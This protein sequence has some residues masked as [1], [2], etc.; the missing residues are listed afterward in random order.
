MFLITGESEKP[1]KGKS[2]E[3]PEEE[4]PNFIHRTIWLV[5]I[6]LAVSISSMT[7]QALLDKSMDPPG[8][9]MMNN[10][11]VR[12]AGRTVYIIIIMCIPTIG[13]ID[14]V[15]FL[16]IIS[17]LLSFV[18]HWEWVGALEKGGGFLEPKGLTV[19]MKKELKETRSQS[20]D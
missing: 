18:I 7:F 20:V 19:L 11:Y 2:F 16:G 14:K 13:H 9:L 15:L 10:R 8:T 17:I 6:S 12:L 1:E 5:S 4:M 3:I